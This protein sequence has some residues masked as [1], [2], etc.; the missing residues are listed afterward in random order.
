MCKEKRNAFRDLEEEYEGKCPHGRPRHRWVGENKPD[1]KNI[2]RNDL[3][4]VQL[5]HDGDKQ[6]DL[7]NTTINFQVP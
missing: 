6:H 5:A 1:L 4:W 3:E 7:V 2:G